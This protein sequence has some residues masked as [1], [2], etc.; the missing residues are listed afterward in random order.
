[1]VKLIK[2][3][4][5]AILDKKSCF[6]IST[7]APLSTC[8]STVADKAA[9][10]GS[11]CEK[12]LKGSSRCILNDLGSKTNNIKKTEISTGVFKMNLLGIKQR[13]QYIG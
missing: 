13:P 7:D 6:G 3:K 4:G 10:S 2:D 1:V 8:S 11:D 12:F 9:S 5:A